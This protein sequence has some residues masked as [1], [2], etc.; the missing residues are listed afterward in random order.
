MLKGPIDR[1][2]WTIAG[3]VTLGGI[4]SSVDTTMVNVALESL[5][6]DF[7]ASLTSVQWVAT[8]YLLGLVTTIP[9]TGWASDR[10][11][12]RR[13]WITSVALF[14]LGSA[15]AGFAW[16]LGSLIVFRLLQGIGGGMIVPAGQSLLSRA[17]GPDRMGRMMSILGV[18]QLLGPVLG[19]VL[20]GTLLEHAS[21]RWIFF[22]NVPIAALAIPLGAMLLP[23]DAARRRVRFDGVG[24]MLISPGMA[25]VIYGM[26]EI[27]QSDALSPRSLVPIAAGIALVAGFG[28]RACRGGSLLDL[29]LLR[30]RAFAA[31]AGTSFLLGIGLYAMLFLLPLYYQG[32]RGASPLHAGLLLIP[33]G[34]GTAITM[35]FAGRLTDRAGSGPVVLGGL[36]VMLAG[37]LPFALA[38]PSV[39]DPVLA[40][41]LVVRGVGMGAATMPA[42][43]GAYASLDRSSLAQAAA[44]IN[45]V[46]RLGGSL[47][48]AL[49]A[50][51][52][53]HGLPGSA[54]AVGDR[55]ASRAAAAD[56]FAD[57]FWCV[58]GVCA[59]AVVPALFL[60]R[61]PAVAPPARAAATPLELEHVLVIHV[62]RPVARAVGSAT[63]SRGDEGD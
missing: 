36:A 34:I 52:L 20:G 8:A 47:G 50:V 7:N 28:L 15:L 31:G 62:E 13:V 30:T 16:S 63:V 35:P 61:R 11:G 41:A 32:A 46:R 25:A 3:V 10:F 38:G 53:E 33:Q 40:A 58:F 56:A 37:T 54:G 18:Q 19:P 51:V 6:R 26:T 55:V 27:E 17:A 5:A 39:T 4:M 42:M 45:V 60:P 29:G 49:V 23:A 24:L 22:V 12:G 57:S 14:V 43:A 21:W 1:R 9:L 2:T 48:V 59:L 44:L